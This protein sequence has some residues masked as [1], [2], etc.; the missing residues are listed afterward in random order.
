M[1]KNGVEHVLA[2]L[3]PANALACE[4]ALHTGL[5]IG[6]VLALDKPSLKQKFYVTESK[7]GKKKLVSLTRDL[8]ERALKSGDSRWIF[9]HAKDPA[10]HRTRQ[11]VW[12]DVKRAA[13]ALRFRNVSPH[14]LR[15]TYA[16]EHFKAHGCDLEK[17]RRALNH[18]NAI[19]TTIYALA[20]KIGK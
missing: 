17:T 19:V 14:S 6:D 18:D 12:R 3:T 5:R 11:A 20:D 10:R 15:K 7:T 9:P 4:I 2:L 1:H 16:V 13:R 8:Y